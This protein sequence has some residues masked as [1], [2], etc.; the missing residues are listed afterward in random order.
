MT[1]APA[2]A[3]RLADLARLP[4]WLVSALAYRVFPL[5]VHMRLATIMGTVDHRRPRIATASPA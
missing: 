4:L 5:S 2:S 1:E 3:W